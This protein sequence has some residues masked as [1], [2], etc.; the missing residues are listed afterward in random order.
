MVYLLYLILSH[1]ILTGIDP[2]KVG[3]LVLCIL[4]VLDTLNK[5]YGV[6]G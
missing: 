6:L 5:C 1:R 2:L 3:C 4:S